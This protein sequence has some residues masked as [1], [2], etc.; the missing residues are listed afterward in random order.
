[1]NELGGRGELL[2]SSGNLGA[3]SNVIGRVRVR[4][5]TV[6]PASRGFE[7]RLGWDFSFEKT[8]LEAAR[9]LRDG[10]KTSCPRSG[11]ASHGYP[12]PSL[13]VYVAYRE[14]EVGR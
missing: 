10:W 8:F 11:W 12:E 4:L 13:T 5:G 7:R 1:L 3:P 6:T 2:A 14:A 9:V